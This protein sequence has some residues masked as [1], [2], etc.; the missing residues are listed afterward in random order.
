MVHV[1]PLSRRE[2]IGRLAHWHYHEWRHLYPN[3]TIETVERDLASHCDPNRIPITLV[4]VDD[5]ELIGS[6]SLLEDDDLP[7]WSHFG[8]WLASLYVRADCR[9]RGYG[10][11]LVAAAVAAARRQDIETL[12]LFTP[13]QRDFYTSLGWRPVAETVCRSER[14]TVMSITTTDASCAPG[15]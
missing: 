1:E 2:W 13:G 11:M 8:P 10:K 9:G 12:Y 15:D 3:W 5:G 4:A 14:V 7:G 6:V